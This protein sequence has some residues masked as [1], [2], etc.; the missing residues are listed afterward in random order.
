[1]IE[2]LTWSENEISE[3]KYATTGSHIKFQVQLSYMYQYD[4]NM[5]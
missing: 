5:V 4:I 3:L 1:M 2:L